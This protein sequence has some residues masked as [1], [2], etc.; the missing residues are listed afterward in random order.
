MHLDFLKTNNVS[1]QTP[2]ILIGLMLVKSSW[3]QSVDLRIREGTLEITGG[4]VT[5]PQKKFLQ[6]KLV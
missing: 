2:N 1:P 6:G 5:I 4:G 3:S